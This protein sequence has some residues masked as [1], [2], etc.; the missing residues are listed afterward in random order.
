[1]QKRG[2]RGLFPDLDDKTSEHI[3]EPIHKVN[4]FIEIQFS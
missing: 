4:E 3:T 2:E 1:M